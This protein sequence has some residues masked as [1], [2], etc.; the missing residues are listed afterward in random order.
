MATQQSDV[1]IAYANQVQSLVAQLVAIRAAATAIQTVNTANPLAAGF[2]NVLNTTAL[3]S[4]GQV[5]VSDSA[6]NTAHAIDPRL[7]PALNRLESATDLSNGLQ[8]LV[9]FLVFCGGTQPEANA[10]RPQQLD[11]LGM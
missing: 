10:A 4:D 9:D 2:W 8:I 11:K 5:G 3:A 1:A 7:Y 6:P